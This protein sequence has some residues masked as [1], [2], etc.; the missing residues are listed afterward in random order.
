MAQP[1]D[2]CPFRRPF[3]DGF[4]ECPAYVPNLAVAADS[5]RRALPVIWTCRNLRPGARPEGGGYYAACRLGTADQ[6][7]CWS[8]DGEQAALL[9]LRRSLLEHM[10][11]WYRAVYEAKLHDSG[12]EAAVE[13]AKEEFRRWAAAARE[14]VTGAGV[15]PGEL[16]ACHAEALDD[17]ERSPA[18]GLD[19]SIPERVT[20]KYDQRLRALLRPEPAG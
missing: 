17:L 4:D 3:P 13:A 7:R 2:A 19:W 16:V 14:G 20:R 15:D 6:R 12:V 1:Q 9:H 18:G 11:P 5:G 10:H 8:E